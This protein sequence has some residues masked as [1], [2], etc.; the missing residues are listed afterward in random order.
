MFMRETGRPNLYPL[1]NAT[2]T[3]Y[4]LGD[5]IYANG[6]GA[7]IPADATSGDHFGIAAES[8][9]S[10]DDRYTTAGEIMVDLLMPGD[11]VRCNDVDG[12]LAASDEG[13][14]MDLSNAESV[15]AGATSKKVVTLVKY[16]SA[17]EGIFMVN[18]LANVYRVVTS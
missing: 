10:T 7:F 16:I 3:E 11:L 6:S 8:I 13:T 12:T 9:A 17:T 15:N 5:L 14:T 2:S 18:A 1:T 4:N